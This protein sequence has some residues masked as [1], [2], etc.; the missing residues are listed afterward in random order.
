MITRGRRSALFISM[1]GGIALFVLAVTVFTVAIQ[2]RRVS[3]EAESAVELIEDLRLVSV[4]RSEMAIASQLQFVAPEQEELI[5]ATLGNAA[6]AQDAASERL[7]DHEIE[8]VQRAFDRFA[9][10]MESQTE[11]ISRTDASE[12]E[13]IA[14]EQVTA[15]TFDALSTELRARQEETVELLRNANDLM[16]TVGMISTFVVAFVVP[17]AALYV[18][19]ALRRTPRRMRELHLEVEQIHNRSQAIATAMQ[20]ELA[21]MRLQLFSARVQ[22][23]ES[24]DRQVK[25]SLLRLDHMATMNGAKQQL[26]F[27]SV[28]P[29]EIS[30][31]VQER[32]AGEE[33]SLHVADKPA[34][35]MADPVHVAFIVHELVSNAINHGGAPVRI[36]VSQHEDHIRIAVADEG[37]RGMPSVVDNAVF[38]E[39][40][41]AL[42]SNLASGRYGF[43]LIAARRSAQAMAGDLS[44]ERIENRTVLTLA[45]P[46]AIAAKESGRRAA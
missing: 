16:N 25:R 31:E 37:E 4:A 28:E 18:F 29:V 3:T 10:A 35:M 2:A 36:V 39:R 38:E 23:P 42:R 11:T 46:A 41:Y 45:L 6:D 13:L 1:V 40:E 17:S 33:V 34:P 20:Q 8:T 19:E 26:S 30:R 5:I 14:V 15:N 44:H 32:F 7:D 22:D 21:S 24:S 43:G 9:A 12:Q 27:S